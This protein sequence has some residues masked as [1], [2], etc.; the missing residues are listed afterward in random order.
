[1][2]KL[3][4]YLGRLWNGLRRLA[5]PPY[6]TAVVHE[7]L[8]KQLAK[9]TLYIV[10]EDGIHEHAAM[11]CPCGCG[12]I[13]QM[14]LLPDDRPCWTLTWHKDGTATLYPSVWRKIDCRSHFWF[15]EGRV[16]WCASDALPPFA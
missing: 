10:E 15:R 7:Y 1:V 6:R 5:N 8:P 12:R 14:N 16:F 4:D 11:I 3:F 13:L 2:R 9:R